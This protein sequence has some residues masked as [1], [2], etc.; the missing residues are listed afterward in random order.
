MK[1]DRKKKEKKK[2][3]NGRQTNQNIKTPWHNGS[4]GKDCGLKVR[5]FELQLRLTFTFGK[6]TPLSYSPRAMGE[7]VFLL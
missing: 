5:E 1:K 7:I 2:G 6:G 3:R 4:S